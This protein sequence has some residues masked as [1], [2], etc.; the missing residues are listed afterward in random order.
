MR[1]AAHVADDVG[2]RDLGEVAADAERST[3]F[4]GTDGS[5]PIGEVEEEHAGDRQD[6]EDAEQGEKMRNPRLAMIEYSGGGR[7]VGGSSRPRAIRLY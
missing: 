6:E 3:A 2:R 5:R 1:D 7:A 4:D